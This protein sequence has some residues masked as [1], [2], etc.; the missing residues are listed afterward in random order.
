MHGALVPGEEVVS[1]AGT[2]EGLDTAIVR[3][4]GDT[5]AFFRELDILEIVA[6]PRTRAKTLPECES[7]CVAG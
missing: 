6:K 3:T 2:F 1:C 5:D 4:R 7:P